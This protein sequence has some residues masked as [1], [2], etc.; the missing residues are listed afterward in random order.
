[1]QFERRPSTRYP[2]RKSHTIRETE[3]QPDLP[4]V[5]SSLHAS[6]IRSR[7]EVDAS[8]QQHQML[9]RSA[10]EVDTTISNRKATTGSHPHLAGSQE[11]RVLPLPNLGDM[12]T[13]VSKTSTLKNA[14]YGRPVSMFSINSAVTSATATRP[15]SMHSISTAAGH[16]KT[17]NNSLYTSGGGTLTR[18]AGPVSKS[19]GELKVITENDSCPV[20]TG[21]G[22]PRLQIGQQ[23]TRSIV[24]IYSEVNKRRTTSSH[25]HQQQE[26]KNARWYSTDSA[27]IEYLKWV[28]ESNNTNSTNAGNSVLTA[29]LTP[30]DSSASSTKSTHSVSKSDSDSSTRSSKGSSTSSGVSS[31]AGSSKSAKPPSGS[32]T[33]AKQK[34]ERNSSPDSGCDMSVMVAYTKEPRVR[35]PEDYSPNRLPVKPTPAPR[36]TARKLRSESSSKLSATV[37]GANLVTDEELSDQGSREETVSPES[38]TKGSMSTASLSP[39]SNFELTCPYSRTGIYS[40]EG[41]RLQSELS[42]QT[43]ATNSS[44]FP[45]P[46]QYIHGRQHSAS[47]SVGA[48]LERRQSE[49]DHY[50]S[51]SGTCSSILS[52]SG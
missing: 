13:D 11:L 47:G 4:A 1:M 29:K 3:S 42:H 27:D 23:Y 25:L 43:S 7:Y 18:Q 49:L 21:T 30:T 16:H 28:S 15:V 22:Y 48:P 35:R 40:L 31:G 50:S 46:P 6:A 8:V 19:S 36:Q 12:D 39:R 14:G 20:A 41:S 45:P 9:S 17:A 38:T 33:E 26:P 51:S 44:D 24:D 37:D 5:T 32:K 34:T 10:Y 52:S 2:R